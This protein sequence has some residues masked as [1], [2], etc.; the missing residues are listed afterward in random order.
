MEYS[1]ENSGLLPIMNKTLKNICLTIM[2][3]KV[4][5]EFENLQNWNVSSDFCWETDRKS[6]VPLTSYLL[7]CWKNH[8]GDPRPVVIKV[9]TSLCVVHQES[10]FLVY[11]VLTVMW[12]P[13][14]HWAECGVTLIKVHVVMWESQGAVTA[15]T[16]LPHS[17]LTLVTVPLSPLQKWGEYLSILLVPGNIEF[18]IQ[19]H[20]LPVNLPPPQHTCRLVS[21][22]FLFI[23][24]SASLGIAQ[25]PWSWFVQPGSGLGC[26]HWCCIP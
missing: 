7:R 1:L 26:L 12:L 17:G 9:L 4:R 5:R 23:L 21:S 10:F 15:V 8:R 16:W 14:D 13:W 24:L 25:A 22:L 6:V 2:E 18:K 19:V 20:S 11:T 3:D